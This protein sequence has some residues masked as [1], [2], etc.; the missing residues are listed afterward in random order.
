M[1]RRVRLWCLGSCRRRRQSDRRGRAA[2]MVVSSNHWAMV[3]A[4]A[5]SCRAITQG[6]G[7]GCDDLLVLSDEKDVVVVAAAAAGMAIVVSLFSVFAFP[8]TRPRK[9]KEERS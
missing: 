4:F 1:C 2:G 7:G 5:E 3:D 9:R 6:C 8:L